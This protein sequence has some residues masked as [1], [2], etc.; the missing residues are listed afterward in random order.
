MSTPVSNL[1]NISKKTK[2][3]YKVLEEVYKKSLSRTPK[4]KRSPEKKASRDI[5]FFISQGCSFKLYPDLVNKAIRQMSQS[6]VK[7]WCEKQIKN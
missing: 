3:P 7:K 1:Q 4:G 6:N 5:K 2:I